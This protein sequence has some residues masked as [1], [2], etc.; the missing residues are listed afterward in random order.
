[1]SLSLQD[2][3]YQHDRQRILKKIQFCKAQNLFDEKL[4]NDNKDYCNSETSPYSEHTQDLFNLT[5]IKYISDEDLIF[6]NR[7]YVSDEHFSSDEF[8][9]FNGQ[10]EIIKSVLVRLTC[11]KEI[12][13]CCTFS[14]PLPPNLI[15]NTVSR[16][17]LNFSYDET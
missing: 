12:K 1:M 11:L 2:I 10:Y 3:V 13:F 15:P 17:E 8:S 14:K 7:L 4:N 9:S 5:D 16:I 6:V